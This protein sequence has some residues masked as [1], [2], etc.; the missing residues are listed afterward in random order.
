[1]VFR[2]AMAGRKEQAKLASKISTLEK[3]YVFENYIPSKFY[4]DKIS[5]SL[6][7]FTGPMRI[8]FG[9]SP[10]KS[11]TVDGSQHFKSPASKIKSGL[12]FLFSK[13]FITSPIFVVA[14]SPEILAE[15][16]T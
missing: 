6:S 5:N 16:A 14:C 3:F 7:L 10:V 11:S 12:S 8:I 4:I 15:V 1:M 2:P 13:Y 9:F